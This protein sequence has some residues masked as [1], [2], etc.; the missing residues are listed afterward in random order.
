LDETIWSLAAPRAKRISGAENFR[1]SPQKDFC[2]N[3]GTKR[4][5]DDVRSSVATGGKP[6]M[7]LIV[8]SVENDPSVTSAVHCRNEFD[9][10]FNPY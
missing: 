1:L 6:D 4:T 7:A 5:S 10:R 8:V 9:A 3:I 2:N